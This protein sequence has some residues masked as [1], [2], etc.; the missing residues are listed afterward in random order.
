MSQKRFTGARIVLLGASGVGKTAFAVRYITKRFIGDYDRDKEMVYTRHLPTPRDGI[1]LDI[2][3]TGA[4]LSSETIE[5][6]TKWGDGYIL[7]YSLT[8]RASLTYLS[9][10]KDII[11]KVKGRDCPLTLVG[12]KSDLISAREVNDEES[13]DFG[14]KFNCPKFEISVAETSQGVLEVMDE[15]MCQI[16][17]DFVKNMNISNQLAIADNKPRSKL[18]SMKKAFK[19]RI[20][21]SHSDTF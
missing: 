3:D 5:K 14:Q 16:K 10:V 18:Y 11:T 15:I 7:I 1:T 21:R 4:R 20:N 12:N 2:L 9:E 19:K 6:H 17:R 8:D 13:S